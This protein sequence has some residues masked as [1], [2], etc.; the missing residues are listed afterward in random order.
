[1]LV[2]TQK[3]RPAFTL[4]E[5]LVVISVVALLLGLLMPAL[6]RARE[7]GRRV[8]CLNNLRSLG[9][10]LQMYMDTESKG[11]LLPKVRPINEGG[12]ENDP[13]LLDVMSK[14]IDAP[15]PFR[16]APDED[17]VVSDPFRCPSDVGG[18]GDDP[19]PTWAQL[20]WSYDYLAGKAM[21]AAELI[22]V[23]NPQFGVSKAYEKGG[24]RYY[25][26]IDYK[27]WHNPRWKQIGRDDDE[28]PDEAKWD[29]N[30][31]YFG[32]YRADKV[33]FASEEANAQF[34]QDLIQFGGGMG[35]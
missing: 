22:S 27:D 15:M 18:I 30:G 25:F 8:R 9:L 6:G 20:G 19:R 34:V 35:R 13:T 4:I 2:G 7:S 24:T 32:D 12:N 17:W 5:L 11:L 31:I 21:V 3:T 28:T 23:R 1:M 29:R 26:V 14:Y 10:G 16:P 33:P